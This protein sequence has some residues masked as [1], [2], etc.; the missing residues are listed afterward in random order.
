M[1][2]HTPG[3]WIVRT[4]SIPYKDGS[5]SHV[6]RSICQQRIHPQLKDHLPVV[7]MSMGVGM[8]GGKAVPFVHIEE[9]DAHLIAAAP[10]LLSEL[11]KART[12][13]QEHLDDL[14]ESHTHP[15]TGLITDDADLLAIE[16]EQDLINSIDRV[17]AQ[18]EGHAPG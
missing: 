18:A 16:S 4:R 11:H 10:S 9:E 2:G 5:K 15:H 8:D 6:E 12:A 13:L 1:S 3:P 7:C 14:I 17:I